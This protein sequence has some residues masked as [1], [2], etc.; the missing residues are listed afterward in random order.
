M[1]L[2]NHRR[3]VLAFFVT[4]GLV[5][6]LAAWM[7]IATAASAAT[8]RYVATTGSD[9]SNNCS[10]SG[11]P[12]LTIQH[13]IGQSVAGDTINVAPGTYTE[14]GQI[15][16]SQN[17]AIVGAGAGSTIIKPSANTSNSGDARGWFLVD[18][19]VSF[20]LS[21]VELDGTGYLVYQAIRDK[22]TG[23]ISDCNITN[24]KYN[25]SGGDYAGV[26]VA[27]FGSPAMNVDITNC[28]FSG[29]GRIGV[30]FFG[31]G[32]TGSTFSG[33]TYTGKGAG[34]WL[35]YAVEVGAGANATITGNTISGN[36]GVAAS[37][38][39]TSA[40]ILVSTFYGSGTTATITGNSIT[41]N[42]NG[43]AVGYDAADT[44]VV[45]AHLNNITGNSDEGVSSTAPMVNAE[46]NWWGA[47]DGPGPVGPGSGDN[48]TT[49]VDFTPWLLSPAPGVSP[50][51]CAAPTPI[52]TPDPNAVGG[53]VDVVTGGS[54]SGSAGLAW[55]LVGLFTIAAF[56]SGGAWVLLRRRS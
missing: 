31:T 5:A 13:A 24:I 37:D 55:L 32:V 53:L 14:V 50:D 36:S 45:V 44:S 9:V 30:L 52:P 6:A 43:I 8:P 10:I 40:G 2:P 21:K 33:N 22:G 42:S 7:L 25:E 12:C 29:I 26:G 11:S 19:G 4:G 18:S 51:P 3:S 15:V 27:V 47:A 38:G 23:A 49:N 16:I 35:D 54:G 20:N 41:G 34:N 1:I 28:T 17:L 39:S 56:G 48:V 46:C